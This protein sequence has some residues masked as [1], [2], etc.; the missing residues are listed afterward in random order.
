MTDITTLITDHWQTILAG[1]SLICFAHAI[2]TRHP[3]TIALSL[4]IFA[5]DAYLFGADVIEILQ[6][7]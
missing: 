1:I 6:T 2:I 7:P 5:I 3:Y 4:V